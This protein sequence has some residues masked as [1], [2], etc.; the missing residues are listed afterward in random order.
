MVTESA[1]V[2]SA[3]VRVPAPPR[4][5][6]ARP[7]LLQ[8][9]HAATDSKATF[10]TAPAGFGKTTL[11]AQFAADVDFPVCWLSLD[12][13]DAE[14]STLLEGVVYAVRASFPEFG[15]GTLS[16]LRSAKD[17]AKQERALL[18]ALTRDL[19]ATGDF[20][21]IVLDDFHHLDASPDALRFLD[22]LIAYLP[23]QVCLLMA[24]RTK[25]ALP[26]AQRL[27][28]NRHAAALGHEDLKFTHEEALALL[29]PGD[30]PE[31]AKRVEPLVQRCDGWAAALVLGAT[32]ATKRIDRGEVMEY[33]ATEVLAHLESSAQDFARRVSLLPYLTRGLCD[34]LLGRDDSAAMLGHLSRA[35]LLTRLPGDGE[36]QYRFHALVRD[37]LQRRFAA[38]APVLHRESLK[39]AAAV[40][41]PA[42]LWQDAFEA[43][44]AAEA[45]PEAAAILERQAD[46]QIEAGKWRLLTEMLNRLPPQ[47][48]DA[49]PELVV[50]RARAANQ[51]GK[52][53]ETLRLL[54]PMLGAGKRDALMA[55]VLATAAI[56]MRTKGRHDGALLCLQRAAA[57]AE[58]FPKQPALRGEVLHHLGIAHAMRRDLTLAGKTLRRAL[59]ASEL[60]G[61]ESRA[62]RI[63][64]DLGNVCGEE[65][66]YGE[67]LA[68]YGLAI[69]GFEKAGNQVELS[70]ALNSLAVACYA[71]ADYQ[72]ARELLQRAISLA[73]PL[74]LSRNAAAARTTLGDVSKAL[75]DYQGAAGEYRKGIEHAGRCND[76]RLLASATDGLAQTHMLT[77]GFQQ[78]SVLLEEALSLAQNQGLDW[79]RGLFLITLARLRHTNGQSVVA[80]E[81]LEEAIGLLKG[82]TA[83]VELARAR[84]HLANIHFSE[85]REEMAAA[86][87]EALVVVAQGMGSGMCL[88]PDLAEMPALLRFAVDA[89]AGDGLFDAL[90]RK[91]EEARSPAVQPDPAGKDE[92]PEPAFP[93]IAASGLGDTK[94]T[95]GGQ[96]VTNMQWRSARARELFF[97]LAYAS[98]PLTKEEIIASLWPDDPS[99][100]AN[101]A[102]RANLFRARH[103]LYPE[104]LEYS[105]GHYRF[106]PK[107]PFRFDVAE[108]LGLMARAERLP[109]GTRGR[110]ELLEQ[111]ASLYRGPFLP[112]FYSEWSEGERRRLESDYLKA[113]A[114]LA[115]YH[116][117]EGRHARAGALYARILECDVSDEYALAGA[118]EQFA[119]AG[120][121]E[122][123]Q[124]IWRMA[125][126]A[127][128]RDLG[129]AVPSRI[130]ALYRRLMQTSSPAAV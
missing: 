130:H 51:A 117:G 124:R 73:E 56:A 85:E 116:A 66:R 128:E 109:K 126:Q 71:M 86:E 94:V 28:A 50:L 2:F 83:P 5:A 106:V 10:L 115:G 107:G 87:L 49:R 78:A 123:A 74:G 80:R 104:C 112:D 47:A 23:E 81:A 40:L 113:L 16:L 11:L 101:T 89:R 72:V 9:L 22:E 37:F 114:S 90:A 110:A 39:R 88:V 38:E 57:I 55:R 36:P 120:D 58:A 1:P 45:W 53:D 31:A 68:H 42:G 6:I 52:P 43:C 35:N 105:G 19:E 97:F 27:L 48:F 129:G 99:E 34:T 79:Q 118:L 30:S 46:A 44:C 13:W 92:T 60:A 96:D 26:S 61:D 98:R 95:V 12:R 111:A 33:L 127:Y 18:V 32:A 21:A 20:I 82:V 41:E 25:P 62:C 65:G 4:A 7:R 14:P 125:Q 8:L 103:A 122:A 3:K 64:R 91:V 59:D 93:V 119:R 77:R 102:F 69:R 17:F 24:S 75:G 29:A 70:L 67:A 15:T 76:I 63:R 54:S 108:F 121:R 100:K 84:L